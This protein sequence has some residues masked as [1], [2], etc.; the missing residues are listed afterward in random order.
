MKIAVIP[1]LSCLEGLKTVNS[2]K[3]IKN[4]NVLKEIGPGVGAGAYSVENF[5]IFGIFVTVACF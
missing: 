5:G 2:Y 3:N 4:S 1:W